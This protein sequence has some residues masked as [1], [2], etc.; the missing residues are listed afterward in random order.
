MQR[1]LWGV[2]R[3]V[4]TGRSRRSSCRRCSHSRSRAERGLPTAR[5]CAFVCL[6]VCGVHLHLRLQLRAWCGLHN[7]TGRTLAHAHAHARTHDDAHVAACMR[8]RDLP[9]CAP[10]PHP[11]LGNRSARMRKLTRTCAHGTPRHA[12]RRKRRRRSCASGA[13]AATARWCGRLFAFEAARATALV[14]GGPR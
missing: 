4:A 2:P 7:R 3:M 9:Q 13:A 12:L 14:R 10:C 11:S 6:C 8:Y 5:R 1:R